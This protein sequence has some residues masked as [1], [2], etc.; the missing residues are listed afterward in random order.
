M[1][2]IPLGMELQVPVSLWMWVLEAEL[3]SLRRAVRAFNRLAV[4]VREGSS[5]AQ[6]FHPGLR[7]SCLHVPSTENIRAL[8]MLWGIE[9]GPHTCMTAVLLSCVQ[10]LT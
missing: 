1:V 2:L 10:S 3:R 5:L 8:L 7:I 6:V 4:F 9:P